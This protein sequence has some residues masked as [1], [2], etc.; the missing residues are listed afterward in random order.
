MRP[1]RFNIFIDIDG[2]KRLAFNS[3]TAALAEVLPDKYPLIQKIFENPDSLDSEEKKDLFH[4]LVQGKFLV[5]EGLDEIAQLKVQNRTQRF[6]NSTFFL[7]I[8]PTLA[9]NFNCDYCFESQ[10]KDKMNKE[11]EK[12]L[13]NFSQGYLKRAKEL[14]LTWFGGEPT[15][16]LPTIERLQKEFQ[17]LAAEYEV[18]FYPS[19][20]ITNGYLLNGRMA[21]TLKAVGVVQAQVTLDGP[22]KVHD[23][24]RKLHSGKGT[25]KKIL[26]N[27]AESGEIL[28][29]V[30]R[31]NIDKENLDCASDVLEALEKQSIL[32]K[33]N[34]YF[35]QV[36]PSEGIC[37][38]MK[39][40]CFSRKEFS[41]NL[42]RLYQKLMEKNFHDITY[43]LLAP[44]G[45][46]GADSDS[47]FVVSPKGVLFKCWEEISID[48]E[49]SVGN[50]FSSDLK[51]FQKKN[52][53]RYLSWDPFE[54][55]ECLNCNILPICMGGC[56]H[57]GMKEKTKHKGHCSFWKYNLKEMLVLKYL[58]EQRKEVESCGT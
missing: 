18:S 15:L 27:L 14:M 52:L 12:A 36:N 26:N 21:Q 2:D 41:F 39:D 23:S 35:A 58:C 51:L 10:R 40:R 11:T 42:V 30:V 16:C 37:A 3:L 28:K 13:Y 6:G 17:E 54:K 50:V 48:E 25:F 7:T 24:R 47:S 1:S 49:K 55:S 5:E 46:C 33:V 34:V 44:G 9:C 57:Q 38:D 53:Y 20:I 31:I 19:S 4:Q 29:I 32:S 43:P 45:H 22:E 8:A 56:P